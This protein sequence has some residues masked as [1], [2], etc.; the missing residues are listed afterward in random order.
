MYQYIKPIPVQLDVCGPLEKL[1]MPRDSQPG[2]GLSLWTLRASTKL[3][4]SI[5]KLISQ[6]IYMRHSSITHLTG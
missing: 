1:D 5:N 2:K 6:T 4:S 3:I